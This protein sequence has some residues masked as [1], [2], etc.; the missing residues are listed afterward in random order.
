MKMRTPSTGNMK[1]S[2]PRNIIIK[3]FK[4][5]DKEKT[6]K[7]SRGKRPYSVQMNKDKNYSRILF[8]NNTILKT[9][10]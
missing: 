6:F 8:D 7:T 5:S 10:E 1:E 2:T 9:V 3:L 4:T